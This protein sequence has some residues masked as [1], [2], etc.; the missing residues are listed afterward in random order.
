[1]A[2]FAPAVFGAMY[3]KAGTTNGAVAGLL[4]GFA[5]WGYTLLLPS[6]AT[7]GWLPLHFIQEGLFGVTLLKPHQLFGVSGLDEISH[8]LFWSL[9]A[10]LSAYVGVSLAGRPSI[11]EAGQATLFVD[12]FRRTGTSAGSRVWRGSVQVGDLLPLIGRFLGPERAREAFLDFAQRR[13]LAS[14]EELPANAELVHYSET[15]LAGTI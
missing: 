11:V 2:Q 12:I 9:L 15:L 5:V 4:A 8:S 14:I 6:F 10:N 3:W 13:G 7:S 1:V